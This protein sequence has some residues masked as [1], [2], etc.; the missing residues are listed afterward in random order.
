M[1][2]AAKSVTNTM[3]MAAIY[4]LSKDDIPGASLIAKSPDELNLEHLKWW[5]ACCSAHRSGRKAELVQVREGVYKQDWG[6]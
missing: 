4:R 6:F 5:L 1:V 2:M 3:D